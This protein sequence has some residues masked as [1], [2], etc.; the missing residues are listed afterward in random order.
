MPSG[1]NQNNESI[2][3]VGTTAHRTAAF[4]SMLMTYICAM[5]RCGCTGDLSRPHF[6]GYLF[7]PT[8][9]EYALGGIPSIVF[10]LLV[11]T[12]GTL[13]PHFLTQYTCEPNCRMC[14]AA[15]RHGVARFVTG[16]RKMWPTDGFE[17]FIKVA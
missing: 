17:N 3:L 2:G 11:P 9:Q 16:V 6:T 12:L 8:V 1:K 14:A 7:E 13:K 4:A 10:R 5:P 15:A